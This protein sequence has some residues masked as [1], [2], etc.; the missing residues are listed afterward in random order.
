MGYVHLLC[1]IVLAVTAM[2][3]AVTGYALPA[4]ALVFVAGI[5]WDI[6]LGGHNNAR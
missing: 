5:W 3:F 2:V 1:V 4:I 6:F